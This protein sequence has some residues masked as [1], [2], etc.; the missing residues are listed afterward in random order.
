[1]SRSFQHL[2]F[3]AFN[4]YFDQRNSSVFRREKTIQRSSFHPDTV[5]ARNHTRGAVVSV[6][7]V[8]SRKALVTAERTGADDAS[9]FNAMFVFVMVV[10]R[11][12]IP[13]K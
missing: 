3:V 4:I 11:G 10:N 13:K 8:N 7:D 5:V 2:F 6:Y 12:P 9:W 1:M